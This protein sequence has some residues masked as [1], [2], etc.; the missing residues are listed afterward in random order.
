MP[1]SKSGPKQGPKM[2]SSSGSP[3]RQVATG[4]AGNVAVS[5]QFDLK[6][7]LGV[8]NKA[9]GPGP[10]P[11]V[12]S[13]LSRG[14]LAETS[15]KILPL[16]VSSWKTAW[17]L[18]QVDISGKSSSSLGLLKR[19]DVD[20]SSETEEKK[21]E[22]KAKKDGKTGGKTKKSK[23][24]D[25]DIAPLEKGKK[26]DE[27]DDSESEQ[28]QED[29][30]GPRPNKPRAKP[31]PKQNKKKSEKSKKP[32]KNKGGKK[33]EQEMDQTAP[34]GVGQVLADAYRK[35]QIAEENAKAKTEVDLLSSEEELSFVID[36]FYLNLKWSHIFKFMI[37][38]FIS[39]SVSIDFLFFRRRK[40]LSRVLILNLDQTKFGS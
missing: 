20:H 35:A 14:S 28:G 11:A 26:D 10:G 32:K 6:D 8:I 30:D 34:A 4:V 21:K 13:E 36:F 40:I 9:S 17:N 37:S 18:K 27:D 16:K 24:D 12:S 38:Y 22:K 2:T 25:S 29:D 3:P 15:W 23:F 33:K 39:S 1:S 7:Y 5:Q 19:C 31:K